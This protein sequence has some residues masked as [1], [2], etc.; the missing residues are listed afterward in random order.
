MPVYDAR[1]ERRR[2]GEQRHIHHKYVYLR[3]RESSFCEEAVQ[4][5]KHDLVDL[6]VRIIQRGTRLPPLDHVSGAVGALADAGADHGLKQEP[7]L[8]QPQPPVPKHDPDGRVGV[9]LRLLRGLEALVRHH[10]AARLPPA[11][12][13]GVEECEEGI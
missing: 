10:E 3:R 13:Q 1:G 2:R 12:H 9:Q 6:V 7:V 11:L 5:V 4:R 8:L